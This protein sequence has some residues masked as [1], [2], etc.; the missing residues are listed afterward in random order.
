MAT[1]SHISLS[2][3]LGLLQIIAPSIAFTLTQ[4]LAGMYD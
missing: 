3:H 1:S 4:G 2:I